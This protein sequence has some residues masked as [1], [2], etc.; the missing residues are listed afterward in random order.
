MEACD[1]S[2]LHSF[3]SPV[4]MSIPPSCWKRSRTS[5]VCVTDLLWFVVICCQAGWTK[6]PDGLLGGQ[7]EFACQLPRIVSQKPS[8][9]PKVA[10]SLLSRQCC[11]L[12]YLTGFWANHVSM[13]R[14]AR[15]V[16][17]CWM[18]LSLFSSYG[19]LQFEPL[20]LLFDILVGCWFFFTSLLYPAV[21]T[22]AL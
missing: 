1:T 19:K 21:K 14:K 13:V 2:L 20:I 6:L 17:T 22:V 12:I 7:T 18:F 5:R 11:N 9:V 3:W 4:I 16:W 8:C 15:P 10:A